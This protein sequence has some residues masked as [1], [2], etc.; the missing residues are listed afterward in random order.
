MTNLKG[1]YGNYS[2]TSFTSFCVTSLSWF[3]NSIPQCK[4]KLMQS[5]ILLKSLFYNYSQLQLTSRVHQRH[6]SSPTYVIGW[7]YLVRC[8]YV[9]KI[10]QK[11][12]KVNETR[13]KQSM[14]KIVTDAV[15][16]LWNTGARE[17]TNECCY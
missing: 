12:G 13:H 5:I 1:Y 16:C 10:Q 11:A 9:M 7:G 15:V 6:L 2:T 8:Q 14:A 3:Y 17:T 4:S